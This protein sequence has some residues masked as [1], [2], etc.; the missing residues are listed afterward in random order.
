MA[1]TNGGERQR[2]LISFGAGRVF[3]GEKRL[4][5]HL[6]GNVGGETGTSLRYMPVI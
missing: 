6:R 5:A 4:S 2:G 1:K 3:A